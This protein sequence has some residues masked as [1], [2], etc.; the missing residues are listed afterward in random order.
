MAGGT[1]QVT[2]MPILICLSLFSWFLGRVLGKGEG[3]RH[4]VWHSAVRRSEGFSLTM[5][6]AKGLCNIQNCIIIGGC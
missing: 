2:G 1:S 6:V 4:T 3:L 5:T